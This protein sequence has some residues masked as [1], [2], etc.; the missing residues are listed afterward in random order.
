MDALFVGV[1]GGGTRTRAVVTRRDLVPLGR[2]A[3]GRANVATNPVPRVVEAIREAVE[4][5]VV[6]AGAETGRVAAVSC[7]IAGVEGGAARER[8]TE[9]LA[10]AFGPARVFVAT[11]ARVAL[12]GAYRDSPDAPG[13]VL[14]AGTGSIAFARNE[15][16]LEERAGGWGP[17]I[18]DEGSAFE[19]ARQ[20][21]V[22]IVRDADGRGPRTT[23]R[24][25]LF[26]SEGT[27]SPVELAQKLYGGTGQPRDVAAYFPLVLD[28][29]RKGDAV[30]TE[31]LRRAGEEL[32]LATGTVLRKVGMADREVV[33]ATIG[34]VFAAGP[35]VLE[36]LGDALAPVAPRARLAPPAYPPEIGA[37]RLAIARLAEES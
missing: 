26:S 36:P 37:V 15:H 1:D 28:A 9:A 16:G 20:A 24:E 22:A 6:A 3:S 35:L 4:D 25:V 19:I 32:A 5:A 12:A 8:L 18:G 34:G 11:D 33:V 7:G 23:M 2:G 31:L 10:R 30:A 29:A 27:R 13:A 21:L 14:I 17:L